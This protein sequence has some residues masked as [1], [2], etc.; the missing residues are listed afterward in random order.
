[1]RYQSPG[2]LFFASC[3]HSRII[4][5]RNDFSICCGI[6]PEPPAPVTSAAH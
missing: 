4:F 6:D 5:G 2:T 1:M 3:Q